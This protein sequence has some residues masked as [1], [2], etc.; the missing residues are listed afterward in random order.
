LGSLGL[1]S[2]HFSIK[3]MFIIMVSR[4]KIKKKKFYILFV[5]INSEAINVNN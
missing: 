4:S 1:R 2:E 5:V 3:K